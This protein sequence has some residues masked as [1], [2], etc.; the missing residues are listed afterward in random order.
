MKNTLIVGA[1]PNE[2]RY[3]NKAAKRLVDAG[4]TIIPFGI[5]KGIVCGKK[6]IN[7]WENFQDIHTVTLYVGPGRQKEYIKKIIEIKPER[8]IFNPGTENPDFKLQLE[9][10]GIAYE[11][12]CTLVL[13]SLNKY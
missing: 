3:A 5:K 4:H 9:K 10:A 11:E 6:I 12:S 2:D 13:L 8:V 7:L 1:T